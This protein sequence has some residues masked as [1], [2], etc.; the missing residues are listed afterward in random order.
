MIRRP[1]EPYG[2]VS[3]GWMRV[4]PR[5]TSVPAHTGTALGR[6]V[7]LFHVIGTTKGVPGL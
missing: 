5:C 7:A 2:V 6:Y 3:H 1:S 4:S